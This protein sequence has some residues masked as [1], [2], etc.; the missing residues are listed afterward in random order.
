MSYVLHPDAALEHEEQVAYYDARANGLG[1]RYHAAFRGALLTSCEA[2]SRYKV[3]QSP[4]IRRL[5]L[6]GFPFSAI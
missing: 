4:D 1:Q 3:I 2:P 6:R 5:P